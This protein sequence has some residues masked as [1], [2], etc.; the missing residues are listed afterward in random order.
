MRPDHI[1][2]LQLQR[3]AEDAQAGGGPPA[4]PNQLAASARSREEAR[5][6][7]HSFLARQN[8][9]QIRK[10]D[11]VEKVLSD[12]TPD[13]SPA[14]NKNSAA[15]H[16]A[17]NRG[18]FL[19]RVER[20]EARRESNMASKSSLAARNPEDCTFQPAILRR[21]TE[22]EPRTVAEMSLGDAEQRE[23]ANRALR[24]KIEAEELSK[25]SFKP[26]LRDTYVGMGGVKEAKGKLQTTSKSDDY[27]QR[28]ED[29]KRKKEEMNE[30]AKR[31][32]RKGAH[33]VH[34]PTADY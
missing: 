6:E 27:T 16:D 8:A 7:F 34:I 29:E 13:F 4:T 31:E 32:S 23:L 11:H 9:L 18:S 30:L 1:H 26:A 3:A 2:I 24:L 33:R 17:S 25:F 21:S 28:M 20:D 22:M 12:V 14:I 10:K 15:I 5:Q 19:Q